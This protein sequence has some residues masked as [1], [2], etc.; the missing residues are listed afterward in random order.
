MALRAAIYRFAEA[1]RD[2]DVDRYAAV[3]SILRRDLPAIAGRD[4]GAPIVAEGAESLPATVA[5]LLSLQDSHLLVQGPPGAGKT[6]TASQAIVALLA[7]GKPV[8]LASNG[9]TAI[10]QLPG[11]GAAQHRK[12]AVSGKGG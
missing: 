12:S 6:Y 7:E 4:L 2:G 11:D 3:V 1:I 5:A 10:N 8:G 9:H